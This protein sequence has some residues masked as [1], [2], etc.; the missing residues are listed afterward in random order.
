MKY[1][2]LSKHV[3]KWFLKPKHVQC[4]I[5]KTHKCANEQTCTEPW[6]ELV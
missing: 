6:S 5:L 4:D 2:G 3:G 1:S